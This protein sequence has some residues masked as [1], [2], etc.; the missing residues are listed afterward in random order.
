M[1]ATLPISFKQIN[2]RGTSHTLYDIGLRYIPATMKD[3][4]YLMNFKI[5]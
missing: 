5:A 4:K 1:Q 2:P 3:L